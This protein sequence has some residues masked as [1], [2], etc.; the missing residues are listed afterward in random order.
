MTP[1]QTLDTRDL[2]IGDPVKVGIVPGR[3]HD[4]D[5]AANR[6]TVR[7]RSTR[8]YRDRRSFVFVTVPP[9]EVKVI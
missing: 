6:V 5:R 8:G 3:I 2:R 7:L 9:G 1:R 4:I